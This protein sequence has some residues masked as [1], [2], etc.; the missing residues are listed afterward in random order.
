M[1]SWG[2]F[3]TCKP[4]IRVLASQN[5][6]FLRSIFSKSNAS[7]E[8]RT[9]S[10]L[11]GSGLIIAA[12]TI[13]LYYISSSPHHICYA[14][15]QTKNEDPGKKSTFLF[16]GNS[17]FFIFLNIYSLTCPFSDSYR[18]KVFFKYEKRLRLQ[19]P[20]EKVTIFLRCCSINICNVIFV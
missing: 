5:P 6:L 2:F 16:G 7:N 10:T 3:R 9:N 4:V 13:A 8:Y 12:S 14:D 17:L 15:S 11:L 1:H 19:S 20:P 18:K